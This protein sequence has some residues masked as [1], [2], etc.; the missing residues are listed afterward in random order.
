MADKR[1]ART[2][3]RCHP[4]CCRQTRHDASANASV[5]SL[6]RL[7][8]KHATQMT[9]ARRAHRPLGPARA[10]INATSDVDSEGRCKA[11]GPDGEQP[12]ENTAGSSIHVGWQLDAPPQASFLAPKTHLS[13]AREVACP[14]YLPA[15]PA[16]RGG[17]RGRGCDDRS[18][19][20][21]VRCR[22]RAASSMQHAACGRRDCP[23]ASALRKSQSLKP[24][25]R[26]DTNKVLSVSHRAC[27]AMELDYVLVDQHLQPTSPGFSVAAA[28]GKICKRALVQA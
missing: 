5:T 14:P 25:H 21:R 10:P 4:A 12:G 17:S 28:V 6:R 13:K 18:K 2:L 16:P 9:L 19:T 8:Q 27:P 3:R 22:C 26:V 20:L 1:T 24:M 11:N 15:P 7:R 23:D